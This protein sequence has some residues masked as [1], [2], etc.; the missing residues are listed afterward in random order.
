[1]GRKIHGVDH[2]IVLSMPLICERE[3]EREREIC[4]VYGKT[5]CYISNGDRLRSG[6]SFRSQAE[7]QSPTSNR[8]KLL[9]ILLG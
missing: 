8:R 2:W 6:R 5:Y 9:G 3:R 4:C 7:F 1:M